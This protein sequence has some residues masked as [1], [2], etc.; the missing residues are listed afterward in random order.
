MRYYPAFLKIDK[1]P[2]T[3][4]GGG[5]VAE[6]KV[7]GLLK[8]GGVVTVISPRVT[9]GLGELARNRGIIHVKRGF[10]TGDLEGARLVVCASSSRAANRRAHEEA[11][12]RGLLVNVVDAPG[13]CTFIIPSVVQRGALHVAISTSG[14]APAFSRKL[15]LELEEAIGPEYATVVEIIGAVRN[16]L[17]KNGVKSAKKKDRVLSSLLSSPLPLWVRSG[18]R[19]EINGLLTGLLG[20]GFTLG[21]LGVKLDKEG[22]G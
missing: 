19:G 16:K 17:L 4:V 15:R 5:S 8:A 13:L 21:R 1:N 6:R 9:K 10:R 20:A 7:A 18:A 22:R 11:R 14:M 12:A 2:C 3:V